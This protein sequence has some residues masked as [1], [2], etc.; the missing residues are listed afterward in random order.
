MFCISSVCPKC[1]V[2]LVCSVGPKCS[3]CPKCRVSVFCLS[4]H[5][6]SLFVSSE[7]SDKLAVVCCIGTY[8]GK[9]YKNSYEYVIHCYMKSEL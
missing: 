2:Y 1:S 6:P 9:G 7:V 8:T 4:R 3:V 5:N